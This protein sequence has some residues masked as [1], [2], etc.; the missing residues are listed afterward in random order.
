M[1]DGNF[2]CTLHGMAELKED[3]RQVCART[4]YA[5][6]FKFMDY[7]ACRNEDLH[8]PAW[9]ECAGKS[10]MDAEKIRACAEGD[11]GLSLLRADAAM[12]AALGVSA[13]PTFIGSGTNLLDISEYDAG[14]IIK[15]I[16]KLNTGLKAC[17][18]VH[19]EDEPGKGSEEEEEEEPAKCG[20]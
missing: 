4:Y 2:Y 9:E 11:E 7:I 6:N 16:C 15:E 1:P 12:S 3:L 8:N 10:K 18:G 14:G 19:V 13:S 17:K 5:K 20:D